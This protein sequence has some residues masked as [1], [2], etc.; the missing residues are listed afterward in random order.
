MTFTRPRTWM[1]LTA[2]ALLAAAISMVGFVGISPQ[3]AGAAAVGQMTCTGQENTTFSPGLTN[4]PQTVTITVNN[5]ENCLSLTNGGFRTGTA[6]STRTIPGISCLTLLAGGNPDEMTYHWS[7]GLQSTFGFTPT[8]NFVGGSPV[9]TQTGSI[10]AGEFNGAVAIG[11]VTLVA[12][13][14]KCST[15]GG[16]TSASGAHTLNIVG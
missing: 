13:L 2:A 11:T 6:T 4:T 8:V 15:P 9:V 7:N 10:T 14:T 1:A 12:D 3:R 16:V 5:S